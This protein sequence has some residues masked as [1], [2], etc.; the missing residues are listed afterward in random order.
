MKEH[1]I[2]VKMYATVDKEHKMSGDPVEIQS[3]AEVTHVV[4]MDF[5]M[6]VAPFQIEGGKEETS[7]KNLGYR[8]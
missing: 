4:F 7:F 3:K 1:T 6:M 5:N 8:F 2:I